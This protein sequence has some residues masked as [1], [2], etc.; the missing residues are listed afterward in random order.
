MDLRNN[1]HRLYLLS[2]SLMCPFH[3][4]DSCPYKFLVVCLLLS[5]A[6]NFVIVP[7]EIL[8][9]HFCCQEEKIFSGPGSDTKSNAQRTLCLLKSLLRENVPIPPIILTP[10]TIWLSRVLTFSCTMLF[11]YHLKLRI[12]SFLT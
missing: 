3:E 6:G 11:C 2:T 12:Y 10:P 9:I 8:K 1:I 5:V 7:Q 4:L